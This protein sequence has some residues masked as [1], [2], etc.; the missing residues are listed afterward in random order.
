[1][2]PNSIQKRMNEIQ[3]DASFAS[4]LGRL[5]SGRPGYKPVIETKQVIIRCKCGKIM[6]DSQKFC[7]ECGA[8]VERPH[9][10]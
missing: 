5:M 3:S 7:D 4:A 10:N 8:R 2:D 1:M 6:D 9:K